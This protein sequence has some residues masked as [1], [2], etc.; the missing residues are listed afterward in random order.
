MA[1]AGSA[2]PL[3]RFAPTERNLSVCASYKHFAP[4]EQKRVPPERV[5]TISFWFEK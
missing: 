3:T 4:L 2:G 5:L 1:G